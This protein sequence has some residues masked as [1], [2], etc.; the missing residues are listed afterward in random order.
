MKRIQSILAAA[1]ALALLSG[2]FALPASAAVNTAGF[3]AEVV[4]LVNA[5]RAS[6][7]KSALNFGNK[8]LNDAA[9]Q[10]AR[11]FAANP[12]LGHNRPGSKSF[13]TVF[14]EYGVS[15]TACG[16]NLAE[17][18]ATPAQV[19]AGWMGSPG[20]KKNI[21]GGEDSGGQ[22]LNFNWIGV[23]VCERDGRL[24]WA[25]LFASSAA[26]TNTGDTNPAGSVHVANNTGGGG[27]N[28]NTGVFGTKP[29]YNQWYH[30]IL[31]FLCFG[32]I[33]MWF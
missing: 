1:A 9:M 21:M 33:W 27:S 5:E 22:P 23:A 19:V 18:Y 20:H 7:G 14:A 15:Y 28:G 10:R 6:E 8:A 16:E 32:F 3:A 13:S 12:S 4:S 25:Q 24:Y 11:E 26:L 30:Y 2:V 17:G 31:F 29:Q